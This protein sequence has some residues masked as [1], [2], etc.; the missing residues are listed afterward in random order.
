MNFS[1][2]DI[3]DE[4]EKYSREAEDLLSNHD[5]LKVALDETEKR[6][7]KIPLVGDDF[8]NVVLMIDMMRAYL[9]HEYMEIPYT[10]LISAAISI[11][12]I[13]SP[14]DLIPDFIPIIGLLDDVAIIKLAMKL[15]LE[16]DLKRYKEWKE[17]R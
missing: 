6:L 14:I 7:G 16:K 13:M 10:T 1:E 17:N 3:K 8:K 12:Y 9:K 2:N 15:G 5:K 4:Y 11:A